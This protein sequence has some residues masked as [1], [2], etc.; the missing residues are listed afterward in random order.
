[1]VFKPYVPER[2]KKQIQEKDYNASIDPEKL[3][4]A[5]KITILLTDLRKTV[6][7]VLKELAEETHVQDTELIIGNFKRLQKIFNDY[8][9]IVQNLDSQINNPEKLLAQRYSQ[10]F[11]KK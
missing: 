1:M 5:D 10:L 3:K 6:H 4:K 11:G 2:K 8:N 7:L 9:I